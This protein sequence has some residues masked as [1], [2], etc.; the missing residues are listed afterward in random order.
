MLI[1]TGS[2]FPIPAHL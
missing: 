2:T 1:V